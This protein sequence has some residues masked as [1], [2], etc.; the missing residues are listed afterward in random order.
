MLQHKLFVVFVQLKFLQTI[1]SK[2]KL[3]CD[4]T[5]NSKQRRSWR[6]HHKPPLLRS[7]VFKRGQTDL[8]LCICRNQWFHHGL[9]TARFV[10]F[11][12]SLTIQQN[13]IQRFRWRLWSSVFGI[14]NICVC[15]CVCMTWEIHSVIILCP[16]SSTT[17]YLHFSRVEKFIMQP[18]VRFPRHVMNILIKW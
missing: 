15:V 6:V 18:L 14:S 8:F 13:T 11:F 1:I 2:T 7:V 10:F 5:F 17:I 4:N 16:F 3:L 9:N 12:P